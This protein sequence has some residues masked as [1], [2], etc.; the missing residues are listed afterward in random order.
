MSASYSVFLDLSCLRVLVVGGGTVACRKVT[1][2]LEGGGRPELLSPELCPA[3]AARAERRALRWER[4]PFAAGDTA[5][6]ALV[7]AATDRREVN[8]AVAREA[9]AGGALVNV[10]DA[11][12]EGSF[13]VPALL[14]ERE[15]T[16]AVGTGGAAPLFARALRD[17]LRATITPGVGRTASRLARTRSEVHARW[18]EDESRRRALWKSLVTA[19]FLDAAI[20]GRD[21]DV[22]QQIAR[23][24]SRS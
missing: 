4:R 1:G 15:V 14:R 2:V 22:E 8:A 5:G 7:F 12:E 21:S 17:R 23:C 16:V 10:A 6:Y 18:P 3:L 9:R 13:A 11:P 19:E 24:L 20:A